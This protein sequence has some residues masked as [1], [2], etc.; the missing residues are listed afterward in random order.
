MVPGSKLTAAAA[1][2]CA[3]LTPEFTFASPWIST[4]ETRTRHH[5]QYL[6]DTGALTLPTS[7]Y[8]MPWVSV[9]QGLDALE[10]KQL[11]DQ[12]LWSVSY[13]QHELQ[14]NATPAYTYSR[15]HLSADAPT[16]QGFDQVFREDNSLSIG[17]QLTGEQYAM[18]INGTFISEASDDK[19]ARADESYFAVLLGNWALG[20]GSQSRWW[21]PGWHNSAILSSAARP[22]P[23]VF[24]RRNSPAP[25]NIPLLAALG[26][27]QFESFASALQQRHPNQDKPILWGAR[28]TL[29]PLNSLTVGFASTGI[30]ADPNLPSDVNY[31]PKDFESDALPINSQSDTDRSRVMRMHSIDARWGFALGPISAAAYAQGAWQ[32]NRGQT[33]EA[34]TAV[35]GIEAAMDILG[36][37]SRIVIEASNAVA[38]FESDS[39]ARMSYNNADYLNGYR[40]LQSPLAQGYDS[41][42]ETYSVSGQHYFAQGQALKWQVQ[43]VRW[44]SLDHAA[45]SFADS[46]ANASITRIQYRF[47]LTERLMAEIG[48][49]H[50]S[51]PITYK[52]EE[53]DSGLSLSLFHFW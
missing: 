24:I 12:Q 40:H 51:E 26:P 42:S 25:S 19:S 13:L 36:S 7:S 20:V 1:F 9:K 27:W 43:Q 29:T 5:I 52:A 33:D 4:G 31:S 23:S 35:A 22:A 2:F 30:W 41:D 32:L 21:G 14:K 8:P 49:N 38:D 11:N 3:L 50:F 46:P 16:P 17:L 6:V 39:E 44:K 45:H 34:S 28:L 37:H 15:S 53:I 47:T 48:A 18:N 10:R